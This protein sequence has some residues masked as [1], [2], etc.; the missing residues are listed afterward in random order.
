[1]NVNKTLVLFT[2]SAPFIL[3]RHY[4]NPEAKLAEGALVEQA[5]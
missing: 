4:G 5:A 3:R 1:M 2:L